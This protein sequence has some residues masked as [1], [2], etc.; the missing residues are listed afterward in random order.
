M[1]DVID[2]PS[3]ESEAMHYVIAD[4]KPRFHTWSLVGKLGML[5]SINLKT[6]EMKFGE[7][8]SPDEAAL[9]SH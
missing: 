1:T 4:S 9:G 3:M 6:G 2:A 8:Y 7:N 5:V